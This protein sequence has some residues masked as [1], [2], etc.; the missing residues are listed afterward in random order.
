MRASLSIPSFRNLFDFVV[1][2]LALVALGPITLPVNVLRSVRGPLLQATPSR[3]EP[4]VPPSEDH[5]LT[6]P[7]GKVGIICSLLQ[8]KSVNE[9]ALKPWSMSQVFGR[10]MYVTPRQLVARAPHSNG[11]GGLI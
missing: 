9:A 2:I 1:V 3:S 11:A 4:R 10:I 5:L 7:C 8:L 6:V